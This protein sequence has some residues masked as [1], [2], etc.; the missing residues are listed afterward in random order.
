MGSLLAKSSAHAIP[1]TWQI[2]PSDSALR[3]SQK[4]VQ[5]RIFIHRAEI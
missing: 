4:I 2:A 5:V 3:Q 1:T